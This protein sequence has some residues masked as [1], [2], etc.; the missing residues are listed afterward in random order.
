MKPS[1]AVVWHEDE[2]LS[3]LL[4]AGLASLPMGD[5]DFSP[6]PEAAELVSAEG[7]AGCT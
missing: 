1:E 2:V 7:K 3:P 4:W 6:E 5:F